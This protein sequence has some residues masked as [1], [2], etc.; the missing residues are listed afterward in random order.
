MQRGMPWLAGLLALSLVAAYALVVP[1]V[2]AAQAGAD[3]A[4]SSTSVA[5]GSDDQTPAASHFVPPGGSHR[6]KRLVGPE[7]VIHAIK[8]KQL[9]STGHL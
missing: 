1:A 9:K 3:R 7:L 8:E 6:E 5:T 4:R 2:G